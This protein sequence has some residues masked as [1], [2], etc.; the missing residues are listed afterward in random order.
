MWPSLLPIYGLTAL[1]LSVT[2]DYYVDNANDTVV[3]AAAGTIW[4]TFSFAIQ[5]LTLVL[6][7]GNFTVDSSECYDQ[8]YALAACTVDNHCQ[9]TFP[10]TGSGVSVYVMHAGFQGITAS[11]TI[12]GG[13]SVTATLPAPAP[14]SYQTP[15]V[16]LF[17]LQ[18]LPSADHTATINLLDWENGTTSLYF[19]YARINESYVELPASPSTSSLPSSSSLSTSLPVNSTTAEIKQPTTTSSTYT[20]GATSA[21][22][23]TE[24]N[25]NLRAVVGGACGGLAVL[26]AIITATI[27]LKKAKSRQVKLEEKRRP[28]LFPPIPPLANDQIV[29]LPVYSP[30]DEKRRMRLVAHNAAVYQAP[31]QP[32]GESSAFYILPA[33]GNVGKA[34]DGEASGQY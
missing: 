3:Y 1:A 26:I 10:F 9:I 7:N 5:N 24:S 14:P 28:D 18:S 13:Q 27:F 19:D 16:S 6:S 29:S 12:D 20:L 8:N 33:A 2:A 23:K 21:L 4:R 22:S 17:D 25:V 30:T 15:N 34:P 11:L 31:R 32:D